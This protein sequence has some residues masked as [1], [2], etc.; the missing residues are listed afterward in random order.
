MSGWTNGNFNFRAKF[1]ASQ[2]NNISEKLES[3]NKFKPS[4]LHRTIRKLDVLKYWKGTEYRQF[5][6]YFSPVILK[7]FLPQDIYNHWIVLVCAVT[8]VSSSAYSKYIH[9]A[10]TLFNDYIENYKKNYGN[11]SISMNVHN[12][13]HV[14]EDVR[15]FGIVSNISSYKFEDHLGY[16][17]S[18]LR[19]GKRPLAQIAKRMGEINGC[20]FSETTNVTE[21]SE[22]HDEKKLNI[23]N[24]FQL[25]TNFKD[26]WFLTK[27]NKII[28]LDK[29]VHVDGKS[30]ILGS[31]I[32]N[33]RD[34]FE[35]PIRS[36]YLNI[37]TSDREFISSNTQYTVADIKCKLICMEDNLEYIF[38]PLLHTIKL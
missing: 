15:K 14:V 12:L 29:V 1:S 34:F 33:K 23:N 26:K 28:C 24:E 5:L 25:T 19:T 16:I 17:K 11:D 20:S 3:F 6:L 21:F 27:N 8:I 7:N 13:T 4:E 10:E 32:Q 35:I 36:S 37:Y 9:I 30:V 2:I 22:K 18:L 31:E 38:F